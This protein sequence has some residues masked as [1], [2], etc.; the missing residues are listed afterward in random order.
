IDPK[1]E[2][3]KFLQHTADAKMQAFG[4]DMEEAFSN[5]ALGM[6]SL[7]TETDKIEKK[8]EKKISVKGKDKKALLYNWLEE[9]LFL[10]DSE[11]FFL[12]SIKKIEIK[13][14][15]LKAVISGDKASIKYNTHGEVKAVT[16]N[17]MKI[18]EDKGSS[19]KKGRITL[20]VV[21]DL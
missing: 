14:D 7:M 4:R 1:M 3:F 6:F 10:L 20:Q 2:K 18:K 13:G 16:Y 21:L 5:A 9:L 12:N 19:G 17:E 11:T 15:S 8:I